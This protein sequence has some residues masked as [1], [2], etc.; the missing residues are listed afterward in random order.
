M[1]R[2]VLDQLVG[3]FETRLAGYLTTL[4]EDES[5]VIFTTMLL[6]YF[7][8]LTR[9]RSLL[10]QSRGKS[11]GRLQSGPKETSCY[12]TCNDWK[13]NVNCL[14]S[15]YFGIH[16]TVARSLCFSLSSSFCTW[17]KINGIYL[18]LSISHACTHTYK[19]RHIHPYKY[20]KENHWHSISFSL[21]K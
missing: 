15:G 6:S 5:M 4:S 21:S 20:N 12:P 11:V 8:H 19:H 16:K 13:E 14:S 9:F 17:I 7:L 18:S 3:Y 1:E 10:S 2:A